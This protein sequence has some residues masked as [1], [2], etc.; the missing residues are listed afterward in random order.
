MV[1]WASDLDDTLGGPGAPL[2]TSRPI[3]ISPQEPQLH[4]TMG[5]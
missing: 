2:D 5:N 1:E 4:L 3:I